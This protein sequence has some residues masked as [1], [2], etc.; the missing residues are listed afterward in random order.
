M[1]IKIFVFLIFVFVNYN[2]NYAQ[3]EDTVKY[4]EQEKSIISKATNYVKFTGEAGA[5]GE[6][7]RISGRE[8]RR[9]AST[10]RLF[11]RPTLTLLQNFSISFDFLLSTEGS[12]AR[13]QINQ[14]ALH[15]DWGWGKAHIGDFNHEF[16]RYSLSGVTIRGGGVELN[17]GKFRFQ[18]VGGQVQRSIKTDIYSSMYSR[19]LVGLKIGYGTNE[20]SFIDLNIVRSKD[21][22]RSLPLEFRDT[23]RNHGIAPQENLVLGI[24][25]KLHLFNGMFILKGEGVGSVFSRDIY[26][27]EIKIEDIPDFVKN[28]YKPR[29]STNADYAYNLDMN[30]NYNVMNAKFNYLLIGPGFT[31]HGLSTLINDRKVIEGGLGFRLFKNAFIIQ[32]MYQNQ[33]DNVASQ[34]I[35]TTTRN[36]YNTMAIVKP[37]QFLTFNINLSQFVMRNDARK[38]SLKIENQNNSIM[39]STNLI[40]SLFGMN[41]NINIGYSTQSSKDKNVIR[42][43]FDVSSQNISLM[44]TTVINPEWT[45]SPSFTMNT[46]EPQNREK[47]ITTSIN[48]RVMNRMMK[49]KFSNTLGLGLN[50]SSSV[51]LLNASLQSSYSIAPAQSVIFAIKSSFYTIKGISSKKFTESTASLGYSYRF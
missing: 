13:Q 16:S 7:Y 29:I 43:G 25:T 35:Y 32:G 38:D 9:P 18:T 21:N 10:G 20:K 46:V 39:F 40:F 42:K 49:G 22:V 36:N 41:Q 48:F 30:F 28:L 26:S 51:N 33:K 23:L 5:Y 44:I 6:I 45:I 11:F 14:F 12:A 3:S 50:N 31:S 34:K 19:Y 4:I 1:K 15:P 27:S 24:G 8:R 47:T 17:P 37:V 2:L